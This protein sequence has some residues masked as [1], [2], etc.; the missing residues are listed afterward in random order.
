MKRQCLN[1]CNLSKIYHLGYVLSKEAVHQLVTNG[2]T[3]EKE[4]NGE[5]S[6]TVQFGTFSAIIKKPNALIVV[7][8]I[9]KMLESLENRARKNKGLAQQAAVF[10][11]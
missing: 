4:C 9:R 1:E 10:A 2:Y 3:K 8:K 5:N 11:F 7:I 6:T